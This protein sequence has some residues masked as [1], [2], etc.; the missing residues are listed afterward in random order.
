VAD[1]ADDPS[2]RAPGLAAQAHSAVALGDGRV[3]FAWAGAGTLGYGG[4]AG[5]D[6]AYSARLVRRLLSAAASEFAMVQSQASGQTLAISEVAEREAADIRQQASAQSAAI[7]EAA[8]R[9]AAELRSAV[10]A[11]PADLGQLD[12]YI[13]EKP[14]PGTTRPSALQP[15][16]RPGAQTRQYTAARR[17]AIGAAA[18]V[19]F[20]V[21]L[22]A[23]N[24][25]TYHSFRFFVFRGQGVGATPPSP[26][27]A[28]PNGFPPPVTHHHRAN[29]PS[30]HGV[31]HG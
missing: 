1:L 11:M 10:R 31:G 15:A 26:L 30:T 4:A 16:R 22:G 18:L 19:T 2:G 20:G 12:A 9:E 28:Q 23:F 8:E 24:L 13:A 6:D 3:R 17:V 29:A 21:L 14:S 5:S 7:R 27:P 25:F